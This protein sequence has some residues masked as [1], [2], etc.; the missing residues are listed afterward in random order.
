MDK[1]LLITII[2]FAGFSF[3]MFM[4]FV[5][6]IKR[7]K[8]IEQKFSAFELALEEIHKEIYQLKKEINKE[9]DSDKLDKIERIIESIVDDIRAIE[10][11][12]LDIIEKLKEEIEDIKTK[13]KRNNLPD[14]SNMINKNDEERIIN[15]YKNGYSI[16]EISRELRIPAGEIELIL[17]FSSL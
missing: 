17:K 12:N 5:Y 2:I 16:E 15:L 8:I 3:F 10:K 14:I 7:D 11:K 9:T 4:L 6:V 1:N 13:I